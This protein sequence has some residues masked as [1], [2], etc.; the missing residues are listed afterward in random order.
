MEDVQVGGE[1][2]V[3]RASNEGY[4]NDDAEMSRWKIVQRMLKDTQ[5]QIALIAG[6]GMLEHRDDTSPSILFFFFVFE[7]FYQPLDSLLNP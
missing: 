7:V 5:F 1:D 2:G 3:E 4:G 6:V